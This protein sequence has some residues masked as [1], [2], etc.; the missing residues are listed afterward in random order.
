MNY[1]FY[2]AKCGKDIT[3]PERNL[4]RGAFSGELHTICPYC[5]CTTYAYRGKTKEGNQ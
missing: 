4:Y 3:V 5:H 2:C 1:L